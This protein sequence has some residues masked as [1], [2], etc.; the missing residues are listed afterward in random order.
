MRYLIVMVLLLI[1]FKMSYASSETEAN[2]TER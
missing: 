1:S 2:E